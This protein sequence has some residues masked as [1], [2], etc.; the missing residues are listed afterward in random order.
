MNVALRFAIAETRLAKLLHDLERDAYRFIAMMR[1]DLGKTKQ[2][3]YAFRVRGLNVRTGFHEN[4][5]CAADKLFRDLA[6]DRRL[7]FIREVIFIRDVAHDHSCFVSIRFRIEWNIAGD[8]AVQLFI[9]QTFAEQR[10]RRHGPPA[11]RNRGVTIRYDVSDHDC[12]HRGNWLEENFV[13]SQDPRNRDELKEK[14]DYEQSNSAA[15]QAC[16]GQRHYTERQDR[17]EH[18]LPLLWHN[19]SGRGIGRNVIGRALF[20]LQHLRAE[21]HRADRDNDNNP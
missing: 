12:Q 11:L 9:R 3:N 15:P 20:E 4:V 18:V 8:D 16:H 13:E 6:K 21:M 14:P 5:R 17:H 1:V 19:V 7:A 10:A 2:H